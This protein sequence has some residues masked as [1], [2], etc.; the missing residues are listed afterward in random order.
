MDR[1]IL[2][3]ENHSVKLRLQDVKVLLTFH[4]DTQQKLQTLKLKS[5][6]AQ[7]AEE[8]KHQFIRNANNSR[9]IKKAASPEPEYIDLSWCAEAEQR[10]KP[11][12]IPQDLH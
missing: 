4:A 6:R 9:Q 1:K 12:G 8:C 2:I 5:Q 3:P 7:L 10:L 11:A